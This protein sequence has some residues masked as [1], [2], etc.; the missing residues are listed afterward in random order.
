[1]DKYQLF[2]KKY[3]DIIIP[4]VFLIAAVFIIL[5]ITM[6]NMYAIMQLHADTADEQKKLNTYKN[7]YGV[8]DAV[9]EDILNDQVTLASKALPVSKS[10]GDIYLAVVSAATDANVSLKGFSVN[11][12]SIVQPGVLP[13]TLMEISVTASLSDVDV[14]SF[15]VFMNSLMR[16][17]PLS[18][19]KQASVSGGA[20]SIVM[21]FYY[22]GYDLGF[23]NSENIVPLTSQEL[24]ILE[25]V[26][27]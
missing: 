18:K 3:K 15:E 23:I 14:S 10:P 25:Q 21:D 11:V 27:F 13:S 19:I 2:Y 8:I 1:M 16:E 9:N 7:S 6:P 24:N 22:K 5:Q 17:L 12:G 20:G 26:T 4:F